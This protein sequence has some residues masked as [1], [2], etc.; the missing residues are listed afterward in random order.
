MCVSLFLFLIF[1]CSYV[2]INGLFVSHSVICMRVVYME[3]LKTIVKIVDL[4]VIV[5][6]Y[7]K[8]SSII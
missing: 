8:K 2:F 5:Y 6:D 1:M 3:Y 7:I 4:K